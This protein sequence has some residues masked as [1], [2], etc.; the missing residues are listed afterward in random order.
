MWGMYFGDINIK[1]ISGVVENDGRLYVILDV[2]RI[3]GMEATADN[4]E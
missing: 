2:E 3:S 4:E 1:Y